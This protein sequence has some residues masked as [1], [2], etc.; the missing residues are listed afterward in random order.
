LF[1]IGTQFKLA[2]FLSLSLWLLYKQLDFAHHWPEALIRAAKIATIK[3]VL[4][5]IVHFPCGL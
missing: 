3:E 4:K 1:K 2:F 5:G